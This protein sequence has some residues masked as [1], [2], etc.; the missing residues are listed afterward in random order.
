MV[1]VNNRIAYHGNPNVHI[2]DNSVNSAKRGYPAVFLP[3]LA[4]WINT[5]AEP[6]FE[7]RKR[8]LSWN[9]NAISNI[10]IMHKVFG[11]S[12]GHSD[13]VKEWKTWSL[14][15]KRAVLEALRTGSKTF[16]VDQ[17]LDKYS[18]SQLFSATQSAVKIPAHKRPSAFSISSS[19]SRI[20]MG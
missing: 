20:N 18:P 5:I 10:S 8:R 4:D 6:D 2:V 12:K 14:D 16:V 1:V 13:E 9:F 11:L 7:V 17:A 19:L 15:K 3:V